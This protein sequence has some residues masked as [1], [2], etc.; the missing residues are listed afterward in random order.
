MGNSTARNIS[1]S[2]IGKFIAF[3]F[4]AI[5]NIVLSRELVASD[6]GVVNFA[7]IMV[8]LMRLL[9][10]VGINNAA[11]QRKE[12]NDEALHTAFTLKLL[13][14]AVIYLVLYGLAGFAV[15][16]FDDP[17][18]VSVI[19]L[20][21][22]TIIINTFA[23]I[24]CTQL[25]REMRLKEIVVAETANTLVSSLIAVAMAVSGFKFWSIVFAFVG[26]NVVFVLIVNWYR[27]GRVAFGLNRHV[28]ADL[29]KYGANV[30][31]AGLVSFS[32]YN[33]DNLVVGSVGGAS[34]LGYYGLAF[35][36]GSMVCGIMS[37]TVLSVLF[38]TFSRMQDDKAKMK[39]AYLD[40]LQYTAIFS[41][42]WNL[43]LFC[44]ADR[45]LVH[46]LG[47]GT[48]KWLPALDSLRIFCAYGV[49]RSLIEPTNTL[50]MAGGNARL[51]LKSGALVAI[52][53]L[54]CIYPAIRFGSITVASC[55]VLFAFISQV[56]LL[57]RYIVESYGITFKEVVSVVFPVVCVGGAVAAIY[58]LGN[59]VVE[60]SFSGLIVAV[61][62][63]CSLYL[64][65]YGWI[66]KWQHYSR[67]FRLVRR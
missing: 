17:N 59:R 36:W 43:T 26:S 46:V 67:I 31:L 9:S 37:A 64:V 55:V 28:A 35:N 54:V 29:I 22:L 41:V 62:A 51:V 24:P 30:L 5:A 49:V 38:P 44:V 47:K 25:S 66:T 16:F 23:F 12:L 4:Q 19:R 20:L 1:Y 65:T 10:D 57:R 33:F 13:I 53:E 15:H 56:A 58:L 32:V 63:V 18:V 3:G 50:L 21:A 61:S 8:N 2:A 14:G 40:V 42:L 7:M 60:D 11:V 34:Q 45:F 39:Q 48:D 6:Y 27:P 52:I